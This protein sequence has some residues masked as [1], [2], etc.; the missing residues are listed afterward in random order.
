MVAWSDG[1]WVSSDGLKLHYRDYAGGASRPPILCIP[2]LTRNA[3]DF[4]GV[5]E[6]LAGDWR[7]ICVDLRGRGESA[8]AK[9]P[10]TYLPPTYLQDLEALI[11]ELK[12]ERFVLFGTSL[13]GLM[14]MLLAAS[15]RE[16]IAGALLNDIGPEV[17]TARA[18]SYPLLCRPL[19]ELADLAS[20]RP[21]SRRGAIGSLS[22]LEPRPMAGL[23]QARVPP[24]LRRAGS[25]SITTCASPSRSSCPAA[26][27]ASTSGR[28][29]AR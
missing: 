4:E 20:R 11:A 27:P 23:R 5:A 14:T 13:G 21:L 19:A 25:C 7:L 17:E 2:G 24:D 22:R 6:R 16:R 10:M 28:P 26:R 15:G 29:S 1:Y 12:L 9:D 3:R 8:H 18:R